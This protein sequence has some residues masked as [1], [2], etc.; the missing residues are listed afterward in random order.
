MR[1]L[2]HRLLG[3]AR[4]R[5]SRRWWGR[6]LGGGADGDGLNA[7]I[8]AASTRRRGGAGRMRGNPWVRAA[9]D[10]WSAIRSAPGSAA[11]HPPR[12]AAVVVTVQALWLRWTDHAGPDGLAYFYG[13]G[14]PWRAR[15]GRG[16]RRASARLR[17]ASD[18]ASIPLH[19]SFCVASRFPVGLAPRDR[20][21]ARI[22]GGASSSMPRPAGSWFYRVCPPARAIAWV[23]RMT[24]SAS[25]RPICRTCFKTTRRRPACGITWSARCCWRLHSSTSSRSGQRPRLAAL[26]HSSVTIRRHGG[27]LSAHQTPARAD[28]GHGAGQ[29]DRCRRHRHRFSRKKKTPPGGNP[30]TDAY[31]LLRTTSARSR[32]EWARP[33]S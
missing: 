12:P 16:R 27:R 32:R 26:F 4:A 7:A 2:L 8:L 3:I 5:G 33:T 24:R 21:G 6:T 23:Y 1:T 30:R 25:R 20:R 9:V 22:Q 10:G 19:P 29:P 11:V 15:D 31:N 28:R 18:A 17:V 13:T 14:R